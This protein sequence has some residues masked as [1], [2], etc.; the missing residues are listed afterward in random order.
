MEC[1]HCGNELKENKKQVI[2]KNQGE[3]ANDR[4]IAR[5]YVNYYCSNCRLG[6]VSRPERMKYLLSLFK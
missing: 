4:A 5:G 3:A 1:P 2:A 6:K